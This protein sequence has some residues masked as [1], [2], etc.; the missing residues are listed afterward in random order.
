MLYGL[1]AIFS[2]CQPSSVCLPSPGTVCFSTEAVQLLSFE[3]QKRWTQNNDNGSCSHSMLL[4]RDDRGAFTSVYPKDDDT[5]CYHFISSKGDTIWEWD[6][7]D[8]FTSV[9]SKWSRLYLIFSF[10]PKWREYALLYHFSS[11]YLS[12]Y[13]PYIAPGTCW[14]S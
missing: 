5:V 9:Y 2:A 14:R 13:K 7:K 4:E 11:K 3:K 1:S 8:A 12:L 6:D 10:S